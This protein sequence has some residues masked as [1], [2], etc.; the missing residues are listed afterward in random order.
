MFFD[1]RGSGWG[2]FVGLAGLAA[3]SGSDPQRPPQGPD[4][5]EASAPSVDPDLARALDEALASGAAAAGAP[6]AVGAVRFADG[7]VWTGAVGQADPASGRD[8]VPADRFHMGSITKTY[9]AAVI[10]R[11]DAEGVLSLEDGVD[12][13]LPTAPHAAQLTIRQLLDHTS[14]LSDY[15]TAPEILTQLDRPHDP[16]ALIETIADEPL[17]F[18]PGTDHAY[19]NSNYVLLGLIIEAATAQSWADHVEQMLASF[20]LVDTSVAG[21]PTVTGH[22]GGVDTTGTFDPSIADAAGRMVGTAADVARWGSLLAGGEVV[23]PAAF[24]Q[25]ARP[26]PE[27]LDEEEGY[28]LGIMIRSE[29]EERYLGHSGSIVGF[30]SRLRVRASDGA[31]VATLASD[32][33]AEADAI[34]A[35]IWRAIPD[36]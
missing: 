25:M 35:E 29:G 12:R 15:V 8:A 20:D 28:G 18:A 26:V 30:Q 22:L 14:G 1:H 21:A 31:A 10:V 7:S 27:S 9:V 3:C 23:S 19:A 34:D 4:A 36:P 32:F 5:K 2:I 13:W 16:W 6:A 11:L 24:A 33:V 17:Q